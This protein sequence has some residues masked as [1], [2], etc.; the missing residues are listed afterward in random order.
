MEIPEPDRAAVLAAL[1]AEVEAAREAVTYHTK[2]LD[3]HARWLE[4]HSSILGEYGRSFSQID[5]W[6][7]RLEQTELAYR[8]QHEGA[9]HPELRR[10]LDELEL[11]Q[12]V[13]VFMEWIQYAR[14]SG[15]PRVSV[16]MPTYNR[17]GYLPDALASVAAQ[18]YPD[19]ELVVVDDASTDGTADFLSTVDDERVRPVRV[20]HGGVCA[21]RNAGL[22]AATG[23]IV[24]SLDDDNHMHP[25]WLKA[26][27]W[28]FGRQPE[29]EVVYGGI[30]LDD[31]DRVNRK[32]SGALPR[33]FLRPYERATLLKENLADISAIA[34]RPGLA[35]A[36][37]DES[38]VEMGDWDLFCALTAERDPMMIP[39]IAC[40]YSTDAPNRLSGGDT[41][42]ADSATVQRKHSPEGA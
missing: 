8:A 22:A 18:S 31:P 30:V 26:V 37:F 1:R 16:I 3:G 6:V 14:V 10:R 38:L 4:D 34:H 19:W 41:Y 7:A 23:E 36:R 42:D 27:V 25:N 9:E 15:G 17:A 28:A 2:A 5:A 33:M 39:M 21:A 13:R 24:A 29:L 11:G 40:F 32:G 35:A 12:S 20:P